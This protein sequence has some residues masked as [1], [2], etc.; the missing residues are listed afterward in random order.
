VGNRASLVQLEHGLIEEVLS[1]RMSVE[2]VK[3]ENGALRLVLCRRGLVL[4]VLL[5]DGATKLALALCLVVPH[6]LRDVGMMWLDLLLLPHVLRACQVSG[7]LSRVHRL[8]MFARTATL[9]LGAQKRLLQ[10]FKAAL[11]AAAANGAT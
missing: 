8:E 5:G 3:L 4:S 11:S 6:V 2:H 7:V 1:L 10:K 9:A